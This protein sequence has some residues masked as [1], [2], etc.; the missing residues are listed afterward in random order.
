MV[1][2]KRVKYMPKVYR[3]TPFE[4]ETTGGIPRQTLTFGV[5]TPVAPV[6]TATTQTTF[7]IDISI[8]AGAFEL[9]VSD[10]TV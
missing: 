1:N 4:H 3:R 7:D 9:R 5:P 8:D 2:R 6:H 10:A